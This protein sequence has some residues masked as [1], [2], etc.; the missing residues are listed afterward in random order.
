MKQNLDRALREDLPACL[1][2]EAVGVVS[3]ARTEDHREAVQAFV[4]KR[5]PNFRG[6]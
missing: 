3:T 5:P 2:G 1:A 4:E 6:R